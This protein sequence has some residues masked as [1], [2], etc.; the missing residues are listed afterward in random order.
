M[1]Q[2]LDGPPD[3]SDP[4]EDCVFLVGHVPLDQYLDFL[5]SDAVGVSRADRAAL[6]A[7]WRAADDRRPGRGPGLARGGRPAAGAGG[8]RAALARD[9]AAARPGRPP[10]GAAAAGDAAIRG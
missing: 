1:A 4:A 6:A 7:D 8:G 3:P 2:S 10:G 9:A 5:E